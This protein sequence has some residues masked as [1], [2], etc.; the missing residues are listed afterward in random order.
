MTVHS[1]GVSELRI[2]ND[3]RFCRWQ[4]SNISGNS[5]PHQLHSGAVVEHEDSFMILGGE[6][7]IN[8]FNQYFDKIYKYAADGGHWVEVPTRLS[9]G[10]YSLIAITV[11]SSFFKSCSATNATTPDPWA[12]LN[13]TKLSFVLFYCID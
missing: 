8:G 11:K 13:G 6:G 10:K 4:S 3:K 9:E 12:H 1:C 5:L 2:R 7:K